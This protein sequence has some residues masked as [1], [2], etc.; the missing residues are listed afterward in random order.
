MD[1]HLVRITKAEFGIDH[2]N[3]AMA[4]LDKAKTLVAASAREPVT[5]LDELAE[6][7]EAECRA[8]M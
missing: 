3:Y 1:E 7:Q 4:L 6:A 5:I 8:L 2:S